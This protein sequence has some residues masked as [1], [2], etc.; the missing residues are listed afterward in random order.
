[1]VVPFSFSPFSGSRPG[2]RWRACT[3]ERPGRAA[4]DSR[5]RHGTYRKPCAY[6]RLTYHINVNDQWRLAA[7][8]RV[9]DC[10]ARE[11]SPERH[12]VAPKAKRTAPAR[13][14]RGCGPLRYPPSRDPL[15]YLERWIERMPA[16]RGRARRK[17]ACRLGCRV[18][19]RRL[20][21]QPVTFF[22]LAVDRTKQK[23]DQQRDAHGTPFPN[24]V[25]KKK[26]GSFCS[27]VPK[28]SHVFSSRAAE[29][30]DTPGRCRTDRFAWFRTR[31][32]SHD[33][34]GF[35]QRHPQMSCGQKRQ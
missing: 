15:F 5:P 10:V 20:L 31:S 28:S 11:R 35:A 27:P 7:F 12:L 3:E 33:I 13:C 6:A 25:R 30:A 23:K 17:F 9:H 22:V 32:R 26:R 1:M 16:P 14:R 29:P 34:V 21:H 19:N 18:V 24:P 8:H 2:F 4:I